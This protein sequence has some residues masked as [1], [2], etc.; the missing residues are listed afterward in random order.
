MRMSLLGAPVVEVDGA[1]LAVDTRK[2]T[3]M[4]AFLAV[5]GHAH[6]RAVVADLLWPE[7]DGERAGGALRRT[8]STVFRRLGFLKGSIDQKGKVPW[9]GEPEELPRSGDLN[10]LAGGL[11]GTNWLRHRHGAIRAGLRLQPRATARCRRGAHRRPETVDP[12]QPPQS[13][14]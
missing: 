9:P 4:L 14:R 6:S 12:G 5:T 7:L 8:L 13:N 2:A 11:L 3:A 1:P 10:A